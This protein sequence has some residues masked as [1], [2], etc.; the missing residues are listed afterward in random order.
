MSYLDD[1]IGSTRA[2][3]DEVKQKLTE[4]VLEQRVASAEPPRDFRAAL[5]GPEVAIVAEIKR[6]TPRAGPLDL[7]LD[8]ARRARAY[9]EGG[10]AALSVLTEPDF[11]RGSLEDLVAARGVSIPV[12]RKDFILDPIQ[13]Y[14]SRAAGADAVLLIVRILGDELRHLHSLV[15]SLGISALVEVHSETDLDRALDVGADLIGINHRD[16]VTFE[17]DPDR[18]RKL[19]PQLPGGVVLVALSGTTSRSEI[20]SLAEAGADAV[21]VGE[22]LVTADD[23][24]AKLRELLGR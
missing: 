6:A 11:F 5:Q 20:E 24:I 21:L 19:A 8:A 16:L 12:L 9:E 3:I 23:P 22:A 10:A 14:E 15:R 1:L 4:E 13:V 18:T 2:R 7:D 17:V